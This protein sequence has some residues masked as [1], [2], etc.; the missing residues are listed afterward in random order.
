MNNY[1][2]RA[3]YHFLILFIFLPHCFIYF[4]VNVRFFFIVF[5]SYTLCFKFTVNI[6]TTANFIMYF[7]LITQYASISEISNIIIA[8]F[9]FR[10]L[11]FPGWLPFSKRTVN[12]T[13]FISESRKLWWQNY[14]KMRSHSVPKLLQMKVTF[15]E[16]IVLP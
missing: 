7:T 9:L 10:T 1:V 12:H 2:T 5:K 14:R 3:V 13:Y 16:M 8:P 6:V 15:P 4:F 11:C